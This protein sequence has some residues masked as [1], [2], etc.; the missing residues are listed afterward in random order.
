ML[1]SSLA[2]TTCFWSGLNHASSGALKLCPAA[3]SPGRGNCHM[4]RPL[5]SMIST[6]LPPPSAIRTGPG[7]TE[8]SEPAASQLGPE[9]AGST[10]APLGVVAATA[11]AADGVTLGG[12]CDA[13]PAAV[14]G[15]VVD[16]LAS[17]TN[18]Q[19]PT[20]MAASSV[21]SSPRPSR[22]CRRN[23]GDGV[24]RLLPLMVFLQFGHGP[25]RLC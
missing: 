23:S 7:N 3:R 22:Q 19:D 5:E 4:F 21:M 16:G 15:D 25:E 9:T 2:T 20:P 11:G 17:A 8:G 13:I 6:R 18:H 24:S 12:K 14:F 10:T 1:V